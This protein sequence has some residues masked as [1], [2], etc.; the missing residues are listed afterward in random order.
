MKRL[1]RAA[2]ECAGGMLLLCCAFAAPALLLGLSADGALLCGA[3]LCAATI[4][5]RALARRTSAL[6]QY[7]PL[8]AL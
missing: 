1:T 5:T 2:L 6:W 8:C 7:I 3:Y 4:A